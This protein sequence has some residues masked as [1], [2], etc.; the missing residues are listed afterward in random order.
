MKKVT[1]IIMSFCL[2]LG[3][4]GCIKNTQS[5]ETSINS[6][7]VNETVDVT[8]ETNADEYKQLPMTAVSVPTVT[9]TQTAEDGTI[10]FRYTYQN[11]ELIVSDPEV[12]DSVIVDFLNRIDSTSAQAEQI[13]NA[14]MSAYSSSDQWIPYLCQITFDPMRIDHGVLSL[15]G[16]YASYSGNAHPE[17]T[18]LSL[19]YDLVTGTA[20][21]LKDILA[22]GCSA[23]ALY[24]PII[25]ALDKLKEEKYLYDGYKSTVKEL[26]TQGSQAGD[27]W[28]FSQAGMCFYYSPYEIAP[29][30]SGVIVA[31]IPYSQLSGLIKDA[32]FPAEIEDSNGSVIVEI[33]SEENLNKFTQFSEVVLDDS[34]SKLLL[35]TDGA[36]N[37]IRLESGSWNTKGTRFTPEHTVF[38]A[39]S[40]T[41]GDAIMIQA[42]NSDDL[43]TL[44][45]SYSVNG[46]TEYRYIA[47]DGT[48]TDA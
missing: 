12:A 34:G 37:H 39:Y 30:A 45:L 28:Y 5:P 15:M 9:Q 1:A 22:D 46:K 26:L 2:L 44:R 47:A 14:A 18:N 42:E 3:L 20:L 4:T 33:F 6:S 43:P 23:D 32:Y 13:L 41:P 31:E 25:T 16:S 38:A 36:V 21:A 7:T 19:N 48:L 35:H 27:N 10:L 29:Y 40:L 24:Y 8:G 11:I 17:A